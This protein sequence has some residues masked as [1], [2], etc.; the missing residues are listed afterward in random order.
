MD[1]VDVMIIIIQ[2]AVEISRQDKVQIVLVELIKLVIQMDSLHFLWESEYQVT[3]LTQ[4]M[5]LLQALNS[6]VDTL[7]VY[8]RGPNQQ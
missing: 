5:V 2:H 7:V 3:C 6:V 1:M 4:H 8:L